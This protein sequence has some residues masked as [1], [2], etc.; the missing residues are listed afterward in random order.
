MKR[1]YGGKFRTVAVELD[2]EGETPNLKFYGND[3]VDWNEF[4]S[5]L[6]VARLKEAM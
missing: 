3:R 4:V 1:K 2:S 5:A 6:N